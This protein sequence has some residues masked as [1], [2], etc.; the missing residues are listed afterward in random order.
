MEKSMIPKQIGPI[1]ELCSPSHLPHCVSCSRSCYWVFA[2]NFSYCK[3]CVCVCVDI[4]LNERL[5][6]LWLTWLYRL[7]HFVCWRAHTHSY[8][9]WMAWLAIEY[10]CAYS[11]K[12]AYSTSQ[13]TYTH[14]PFY[15]S[16]AS[17]CHNNKCLIHSDLYN[18]F[19]ELI[20]WQSARH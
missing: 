10:I 13:H 16:L 5:V 1:K 20:T 9:I 18:M 6:Q 15:I 11:K 3:V 19:T 14:M 17:T 2:M 4:Q 7:I 8:F 12:S